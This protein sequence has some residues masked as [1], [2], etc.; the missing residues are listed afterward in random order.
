[1]NYSV[2]WI[3]KNMG[4]SRKALLVYEKKGLIKP[5]RNTE[6]GYREC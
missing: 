1:M 5:E 2:D 3:K 6:N 4:I